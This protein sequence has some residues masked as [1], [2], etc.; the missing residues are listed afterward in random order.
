MTM[1]LIDVVLNGAFDT[2]NFFAPD[3]TLITTIEGTETLVR[4]SLAGGLTLA[5]TG[6]G[7]QFSGTM[8]T[9]GQITGVQVLRADGSELARMDL[10]LAPWNFA[11]IT[12]NAPF[13]SYLANPHR[14][15]YDFAALQ[16]FAGNTYF[17]GGDQADQL[18]NFFGV[19]TLLGG[20]G[21][22]VVRVSGN[23]YPQQ[24]APVG[25]TLDGGTGND[26]LEISSSISADFSRAT[27]R[28]FETL[29]I[30]NG[31]LLLSGAQL[32]A[33]GIALTT[34]I[35]TFSTSGPQLFINQVA[36]RA[37]DLSQFAIAVNLA[38]GTRMQ[39]NGTTA[40]DV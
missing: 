27:I 24:V 13:Q 18:G 32:G 26:R 23:V 10:T 37:V 15:I 29:S 30:G 21:D 9:A 3:T 33:R 35:E 14:Q 8:P 1:P 36:G 12:T 2:R 22:D 34:N 5:Y 31:T 19:D 28:N 6:T 25:L 17:Q 40:N 7:L 4:V 38:Q 16:S 20:G 39:I 11:E